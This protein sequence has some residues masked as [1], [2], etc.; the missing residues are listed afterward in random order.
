[1]ATDLHTVTS[2]VA[3]KHVEEKLSV[4]INKGDDSKLFGSICLSITTE[5]L[6]KRKLAES[7]PAPPP[8]PPDSS[9]DEDP[10]AKRPPDSS[11]EEEAAPPAKR[12]AAASKK[13]KPAASPIAAEERPEWVRPTKGPRDTDDSG[14]SDDEAQAKPVAKRKPS[15]SSKEEKSRPRATTK[16]KKAARASSDGSDGSGDS[17]ESEI[18]SGDEAVMGAGGAVDAGALYVPLAKQRAPRATT[19]RFGGDGRPTKKALKQAAE[20]ARRQE[21]EAAAALGMQSWRAPSWLEL[22]TD[23]DDSDGT[24][25]RKRTQRKALKEAKAA[26]APPQLPTSVRAAAPAAAKAAPKPRAAAPA[27][28][29]PAADSSGEE[30]EEEFEVDR[31]LKERRSG[32]HSEFLVRW[33]GYGAEEDSWE[34]EDNVA[35]ELIAGFRT[36]AKKARQAARERE[37]AKVKV[38]EKAAKPRESALPPPSGSSSGGAMG[39]EQARPAD[40]SDEDEEA[41]A[42]RPA[43]AS[44]RSKP[45]P[46]S[47]APASPAAASASSQ[48]SSESELAKAAEAGAVWTMNPSPPRPSWSS[49][50]LSAEQVAAEARAAQ[51]EAANLESQLAISRHNALAFNDAT[52]PSIDLLA[53]AA[54]AAAAAAAAPRVVAQLLVDEGQVSLYLSALAKPLPS[55]RARPAA[56][57]PTSPSGVKQFTKQTVGAAHAARPLARRD[58]QLAAALVRPPSLSAANSANNAGR[59]SSERW[60]MVPKSCR[61]EAAAA[62]ALAAGAPPAAPTAPTAPHKPTGLA[63]DEPCLASVT[64]PQ[65]SASPQL[66]ASMEMPA[67]APAAAAPAAAAPAAAAPAAAAPAAAAP[68][69]AAP[70]V[71]AEPK[72][73]DQAE[74]VGTKRQLQQLDENVPAAS[75]TKQPKPAGHT[76]STSRYGAGGLPLDA[77]AVG[78]S[79][80][81]ALRGHPELQTSTLKQLRVHLETKLGDLTEWKG[82]IKKVTQAFM[83]AKA[84]P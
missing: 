81:A 15:S 64:R 32:G 31:I 70:K 69:A 19:S 51:I 48:G 83:Q 9:E 80:R 62:A 8:P 41:A 78:K 5:I 11:D 58:A 50:N 42:Q 35:A 3:K 25:G 29:K 24:A 74:G 1:L 59:I 79:V 22:Q 57:A 66:P 77:K 23:S 39:G 36:E 67:A 84:E 26:G 65:P 72:A 53:P 27:A 21:H 55:G 10:A 75:S 52:A 7:A 47:P 14:S 40:S 6:K 46:A 16:Q 44:K 54:A 20:E 17:S 13:S 33:L 4:K 37:G 49:A 28:P 71:D 61:G 82:E 73:K 43:D 18:M 2:K 60:R 56:P 45:T 12:P 68:A 76:E 34:P 63:S 30:G 38:P